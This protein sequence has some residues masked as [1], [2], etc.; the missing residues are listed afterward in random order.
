MSRRYPTPYSSKAGIFGIQHFT[1]SRTTTGA[2]PR[3]SQDGRGPS[4][5]HPLVEGRCPAVISPPIYLSKAELFISS[6]MI[7]PIYLSN[8]WLFQVSKDLQLLG[9]TAGTRPRTSQ[10]GGGPSA[11][12]PLVEGRC[13]ALSPQPICPR[14][15]YFS[16]Q[17]FTSSGTTAGTRP[18]TSQ[19][20]GGPTDQVP[21]PT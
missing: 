2:R 14:P 13:P 1:I 3:T 7:R 20:G 12:H 21:C 11:H 18:R 9:A 8:A 4:A 17:W 10:D 5:H 19:M 6:P 15:R 16:I